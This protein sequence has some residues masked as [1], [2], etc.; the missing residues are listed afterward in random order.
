MA[1]LSELFDELGWDDE[2][3]DWVKVT[4]ELLWPGLV[5]SSMFLDSK[6][7]CHR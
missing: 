6:S 4:E 2:T 5:S 7:Q 1:S 3:D